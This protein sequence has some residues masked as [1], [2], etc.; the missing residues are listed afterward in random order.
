MKINYLQ[1]KYENQ[2]NFCTSIMNNKENLDSLINSDALIHSEFKS[3]YEKNKYKWLNEFLDCQKFELIDVEL[4]SFYSGPKTKEK[5]LNF[6]FTINY[7]IE[8]VSVIRFSFFKENDF[9]KLRFITKN[10]NNYYQYRRPKVNQ[11]NL[12]FY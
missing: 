7:S 3:Y 8:S 5:R 9:Y 1:S 11:P 10:P 6:I 12:P 4:I 2:Y